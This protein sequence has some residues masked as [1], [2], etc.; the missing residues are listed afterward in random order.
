MRIFSRT[1]IFSLLSFAILFGGTAYAATTPSEGTKV[2]GHVTRTYLINPI[3]GK[4]DGTKKGREGTTDI[5]V[6]VGYM[7]RQALTILGSI[8]LVVFL[9]GGAYWLTSAGN[10]ERV[11]KG[12]QTMVWAA[13]GMFVI[14]ASYGILSA[15]IG[16][17]TGNPGGGSS[18]GGPS[19][20][21]TPSVVYYVAGSTNITVLKDAKTDAKPVGTIEKTTD[22]IKGVE[23]ET[24][25]YIKVSVKVPSSDAELVGWI[26]PVDVNKSTNANC[27]G[28]GA[29]STDAGSSG[30]TCDGERATYKLVT[31][32]TKDPGL[33]IKDAPKSGAQVI[34]DIKENDIFTECTNPREGTWGVVKY[35]GQVGWAYL[36]K[37]YL[38]TAP[39]ESPT[40]QK[41]IVTN[42]KKKKDQG[43]WMHTSYNS[44]IHVTKIDEGAT[45]DVCANT[46]I[47]DWA[48][49]K[50]KGKIGWSRL[51]TKWTVDP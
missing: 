35:N 21:P 13:I 26:K 33:K 22:C 51:S 37:K 47:K 8:A 19:A 46:Q 40:V 48:V 38:A 23:V 49:V 10:A 14:F 1:F 32:D 39:C 41:K 42:E 20:A 44:G 5:R 36:S 11:K 6:I 29:G 27:G 16:G 28:L 7:L 24:N 4:D 2:T 30:I 34:G 45:I 31:G 9:V 12:S 50:Y 15:V 3:G 25:G 43:L 18:G 17:L